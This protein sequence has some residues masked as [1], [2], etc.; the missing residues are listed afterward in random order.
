[1]EISIIWSWALYLFVAMDETKRYI[2]WPYDLSNNSLRAGISTS[3][4]PGGISTKSFKNY[5]K[6]IIINWPFSLLLISCLDNRYHDHVTQTWKKPNTAQ[7]GQIHIQDTCL[8][9]RKMKWSPYRFPRPF[10]HIILRP[11]YGMKVML[12][13]A[14]KQNSTHLTFS[15]SVVIFYYEDINEHQSYAQLSFLW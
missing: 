5:N 4:F 11:I 9:N 1:M 13:I 2:P 12:E 3:K 8:W 15:I 10:P 14:I 6:I 7:A